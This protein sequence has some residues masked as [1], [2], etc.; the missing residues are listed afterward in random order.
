M[1]IAVLMTCHNRKAKTLAC[2]EGLFKNTLLAGYSLYVILVDDGSTDGTSEAVRSRYPEVLIVRG[3]GNLFWNRGMLR[4]WEMALPLTPDYVLWLNDDTLL[5]SRALNDLLETEARARAET[6]KPTIIVGSTHNDLGELSYGGCVPASTINRLKMRKVIPGDSPQAA[7]TMNGNCVLV[8]RAVYERIGLLDKVFS[9]GMGDNDYGFRAH[10]A[11]IPIWVM[12]GY[13]GHCN[14]DHTVTGSFRDPNLSVRSR[15][16]QITSPKGLPA[17]P[18]LVMCKRHAGP[19][20]PLVWLLPY[21]QVLL[22][23]AMHGQS[24]KNE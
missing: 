13:A 16:R 12:S 17:I 23:F 11:G 18:W 14:I 15:W 3:D 22:G 9:H 2:L 24:K 10:K 1:R 5:L 6:G 7:V 20:W 4:A 21:A 8:P 19:L